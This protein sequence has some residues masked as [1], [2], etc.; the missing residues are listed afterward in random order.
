MMPLVKRL[1]TWLTLA[2]A[3]VLPG[4]RAPEPPIDLETASWAE[5]ETAARGTTVYAGMW[6]GDAQ[7]NRYMREF[8]APKLHDR[9]GIELRTIA[10]QGADIV[11]RLQ[12]DRNAERPQGDLDMV[13]INGET[14][15]QLRQIDALFGP[16]THKLPNDP[17]VAWENPFIAKDF[18]QD[19]N[20]ME[21]PWG[22]VQ[23]TL[24]YLPARVPHPPQT[25]DEFADWIRANPGRFTLPNDF[26]GMTFLKA[27][28]AHFDPSGRASQA[29]FDEAA[30]QAAATPMWQW[31]QDLRSYFWREGN[32][33]PSDVSQLHRL[34]S[35]AEVDFTMSNN[36]GEVD[37]KAL[38]GILPSDARAYIPAFGS[39]QNSHYWG[40]PFNATNPAGALVVI[41]FLLSPEAQWEKAK[42]AVWGDGTVLAVERLPA[43][44][45]ER[46]G[47][48]PNRVRGPNRTDIQSRALPEP[49]PEVMIRL[50]E[51]FR[52]QLINAQPFPRAGSGT[53]GP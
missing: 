21:A 12:V 10:T 45:P 33:Y 43:P 42:P 1:P 16:F 13:W 46:F 3:V 40:V 38:Q 27:L 49:P 4:C 11:S 30:Y 5:I 24:I 34:F 17:W 8:V 39:I 53:P 29:P 52:T 25:V 26:A 2:L 37:N 9:Y 15:Y 48:I 22:N 51:Q 41:N 50:H 6:S 20:G 19:V 47:N 23:F 14:F 31:L 32:T 7:I 28:L 44:W 18:Q 35:N 36:D